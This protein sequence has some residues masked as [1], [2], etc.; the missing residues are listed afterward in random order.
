MTLPKT[1]FI[2]GGAGFIGSALVR[3]LLE[4]SD[5]RLVILDALTYAGHLESLAEV[6]AHPRLEFH[7]LDITDRTALDALF[8]DYQPNGVFHL[9]AET[10]VDRSIAAPAPFIATNITGTFALLEAARTHWSQR[11]TAEQTNFRFLHVS[12]DEVFGA[13][14]DL[15]C[16]TEA[17]PYRPNSPYAASKAAADHLVHA[18]QRTYGLPTLICHGT[19]TYGPRQFPEKL[20]PRLLLAAL[21][22]APLPLYGRGEQVREWLHVDDHVRALHQVFAR[23]RSG[24]HYL[25]G[26][27]KALTNLDLART[28]CALLDELRPRTDG[29]PHATAIAFVAERPGHDWRY[30]LDAGKL[31]AELGW[32][33]Q[34]GF[35]EGLRQT[36]RWYL[37]HPAWLAASG[38]PAQ[39]HLG[40][41]AA[42][43]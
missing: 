25:V 13:L 37:D 22:D 16:F 41:G 11:T 14:G 15:G 2:T 8:N 5:W 28:L 42:R 21:Q 32:R 33:P 10:H 17:S 39:R 23:G 7:R 20:I 31:A 29:R 38:R 4:K 24:E 36:V 30:A 26:G 1:V 27:G 12:T 40:E 9:A 3:L 35:A 34:T 43:P 18:W 6:L 19:N